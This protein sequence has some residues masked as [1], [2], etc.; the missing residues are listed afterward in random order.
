VVNYL[1]A[2]RAANAQG[3]DKLC[4]LYLL[5]AQRSGEDDLA[6][7]L[8]RAELQLRG[9]RLQEA[10][11]TL[12]PLQQHAAKHPQVLKLLQEVYAALRDW[13]NVLQLLP[14]LRRQKVLTREQVAALELRAT[15][16]LFNELAA[17][18]Q[19]ENLRLRWQQLPR[20]LERNVEV[21][22]SYTRG[23]AALGAAG[24]AEQ[25]LR[26]QLKREWD[27][28]LVGLYGVIAGTDPA[29]QLAQA[30]QWLQQHSGNP[31]LLLCL[32]RLAL[33]NELWG[34]ARDYFE[35]SLKLADDPQTY[36]ELGH[37][38][39]RL[40]QHERSSQYYARGLSVC[41]PAT[42]LQPD[43]AAG[44]QLP[45]AIGLRSK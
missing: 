35:A 27:A 18:G 4:E 21:V 1:L 12:L 15:V 11:A 41:V 40:G 16:D 10:L 34:K 45:A 37:L 19:I 2:A 36:A 29:R 13:P 7:A 9:G 31:A 14:Q 43:A 22:A 6:V 23:L 3:E 28:T 39:A 30:E 5:R 8:T 20:A 25:I 44:S 32:G 24:E 33:R 42:V 38:L 26:Q 17:Q